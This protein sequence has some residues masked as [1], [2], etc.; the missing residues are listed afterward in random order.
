MRV[1][2]PLHGIGT[3]AN[4]HRTLS[5]ALQPVKEWRCDLERWYYGKF[6]F[7][8]FLL[9]WKRSGQIKWFRQT[10]TALMDDRRFALGKN[11]LPSIVAHSFGTYI[12]GYALR[13]FP[14]IKFQRTFRGMNY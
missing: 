5:D 14:N 8:R 13:K 11:N 9:P 6:S 2:A 4:W 7:F 3:T 10:Y 12:L 1:I